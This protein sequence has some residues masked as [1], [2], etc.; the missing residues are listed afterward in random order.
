MLYGKGYLYYLTSG[1]LKNTLLLP[2]EVLLTLMVLR[3]MLPALARSGLI[4][5]P[6]QAVIRWL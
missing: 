2:V 3:L 6:A 1:L 5:R 4:P